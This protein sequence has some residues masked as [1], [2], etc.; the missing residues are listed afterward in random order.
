MAYIGQKTTP[1]NW[2][3]P[4]KIIYVSS[5]TPLSIFSGR[6]LHC[7]QQFKVSNLI[8]KLFQQEH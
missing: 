8:L 2:D 7:S 5:A 6:I 4:Y 1:F 3:F